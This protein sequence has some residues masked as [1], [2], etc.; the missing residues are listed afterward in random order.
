MPLFSRESWQTFIYKRAHLG[1]PSRLQWEWLA[2]TLAVLGFVTLLCSTGPLKRIE[3]AQYDHLLRYNRQAPSPDILL[4]A[5]D[6]ASLQALGPW[7]WPRQYHAD[8]LAQLAKAGPKAVAL[9]LVFLEP[10]AVRVDDEALANAIQLPGLGAVFLPITAQVPTTDAR[11][12]VWQTPVPVLANA[13]SGFGH[14]NVELDAD[15]IARSM[16]LYRDKGDTLWPSLALQMAKASGRAS[17]QVLDGEVPEGNPRSLL[18]FNRYDVAARSVS[19]IDVLKGEVPSSLLANKLVLVGVTAMGL[20]EQ[21]PSPLSGSAALVPGVHILATALDGLLDDRLIQDMASWQALFLNYALVLAWMVLLYQFGPR[22]SLFAML[23]AVAL[24]EGASASMLI[25]AQTWWPSSVASAGVLLGYLLWSWRRVNALF[26][27]LQHR[28]QQ[29]LVDDEMVDF[30]TG[31]KV[32]SDPNQWQSVLGNLDVGLYAAKTRKKRFMDILDA[33][34]EAVILTDATGQIDHANARARR[35]L[36]LAGSG[37]ANALPLIALKADS[38]APLNVSWDDFM[39]LIA[40]GKPDGL[41]VNLAPGMFLLLRSTPVRLMGVSPNTHPNETWWIVMM[42]DVSKQRV[43]Q[44]QR[45]DMM[46]LLW[47]DF[48]APQA[49]ILTLLQTPDTDAD[50][51]NAKAQRDALHES[52]ASQV[53]ATLAMADDFV[54]QLRAEGETDAHEYHEVDLVQLVNEVMS[55]AW[56][57]A[58]AKNIGLTCNTSQLLTQCASAV[59]GDP[60]AQIDRDPEDPEEDDLDPDDL[61]DW[62]EGL[63]LRIEPRL[64]SRALFNL[65]ENAIKYSPRDTH[66]EIALRVNPDAG[67]GVRVAEIVVADQGYGISAANLP[68]IFDA[69]TRFSAPVQPTHASPNLDA[70]AIRLAKDAGSQG[71]GLGLRLVKTVV[72]LHKGTIRCESTPGL[73]TTFVIALPMTLEP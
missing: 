40:N 49:A 5:I 62:D 55:R 27:H 28:T 58:R 30:E 50:S 64:M 20:G 11:P 71:H 16:H 42:L 13:A 68:R 65:V 23:L 19:Y 70:Q 9:N 17:K 60:A 51:A 47:H 53:Y 1:W 56:P 63:R 3:L 41:E 10:S 14:I 38:S 29:L 7:P 21:Y 54:W 15:G 26:L 43:M 25:Q 18:P 36:N 34:P 57:L 12:V 32:K 4:I 61:D 45:N 37:P 44:R 69:Y 52:I 67:L 24:F 72:E 35:L 8:M 2:C 6:E 33:M 66:I 39:D 31:F 59:E 22:Q 46:Q 48:R 73:G